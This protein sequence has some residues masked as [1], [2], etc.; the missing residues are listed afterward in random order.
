MGA[1]TPPGRVDSPQVFATST[2]AVSSSNA[3]TVLWFCP[4]APCTVTGKGWNPLA[5]AAATLPSPPSASGR[6]LQCAPAAVRPFA[7]W[8]AT[9]AAVRLPLN[10]SGAMRTLMVSISCKAGVTAGA[11]G[12]RVVAVGLAE[13]P[14]QRR[15]GDHGGGAPEPGGDLGEGHQVHPV[16][17]RE[18]RDVTGASESAVADRHQGRIDGEHADRLAD[19]EPDG[20]HR[21]DHRGAG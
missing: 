9:S 7:R 6:V 18:D 11:I 16:G 15:G 5:R 19:P 8:L 12:Q 3:I 17:R 10:L 13:D 21:E 2:M 14:D 20:R 1:R 4:V